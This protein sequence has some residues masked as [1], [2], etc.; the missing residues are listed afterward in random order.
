MTMITDSLPHHIQHSHKQS[1]EGKPVSFRNPPPLLIPWGPLTFPQVIS[2]VLTTCWSRQMGP[3]PTFSFIRGYHICSWFRLFRTMRVGDLHS[4]N[5]SWT[6]LGQWACSN[7][8]THHVPC[9][10]LSIDISQFFRLSPICYTMSVRGIGLI[11]FDL[12][13]HLHLI[14]FV[15]LLL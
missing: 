14:A 13:G 10:M 2:S 6:V 3:F 7:L 12:H 9:G 11:S 4:M 8:L 1:L 5:G 15:S